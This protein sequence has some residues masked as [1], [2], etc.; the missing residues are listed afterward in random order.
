MSMEGDWVGIARRARRVA[1]GLQAAIEDVVGVGGDHQPLDRQAHGLGVIAGEDVAE[2]A[3][4]HREG[5]RP[6]GAA[7]RGPGRRNNR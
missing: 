7:Q 2:I 6:V 1:A 5:Q 3:G 4:R